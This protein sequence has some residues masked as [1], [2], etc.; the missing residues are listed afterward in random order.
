MTD[1]ESPAREE[2][3]SLSQWLMVGGMLGQRPPTWESLVEMSMARKTKTIANADAV[4]KAAIDKVNKKAAKKAAKKAIEKPPGLSDAAL[5]VAAL[6][7]TRQSTR[8]EMLHTA[9]APDATANDVESDD[10]IQDGD[11]IDVEAVIQ[12]EDD[13]KV[14]NGGEHQAREAHQVDAFQAGSK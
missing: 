11:M 13:T 12:A 8:L 6:T 3:L 1:K 7:S 2:R 5:G 10:S 9:D 14:G 4:K